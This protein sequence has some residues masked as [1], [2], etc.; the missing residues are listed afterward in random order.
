MIGLN[1]HRNPES[2][3]TLN[4]SAGSTWS[5]K[6]AYPQVPETHPRASLTSHVDLPNLGSTDFHSQGSIMLA[7]NL[8]DSKCEA[9]CKVLWVNHFLRATL[10]KYFYHL[11]KQLFG[12]G[13]RTGWQ[14]D[15]SNQVCLS[16]KS[17]PVIK[18]VSDQILSAM[19]TGRKKMK[20]IP[21]DFK[22]YSCSPG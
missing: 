22:R 6:V 13:C 20:R 11:T 18:G 7:A 12:Q 8:L 4:T 3:L 21:G 14:Q 5:C 1:P 19:I 9:L 17:L 16:P 2:R 10:R 15:L